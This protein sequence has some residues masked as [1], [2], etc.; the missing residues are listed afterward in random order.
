L[1]GAKT[2]LILDTDRRQCRSEE[3]RFREYNAHYVLAPTI[4]TVAT[5]TSIV[6]GSVPLKV[7]MSWKF[8]E[9]D[10]LLY[11]HADYLAL[12]GPGYDL[13]CR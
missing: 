12:A 4:P 8:P 1:V 11:Q 6:K 9:P 3:G 7:T 2:P 13:G 10:R 5:M